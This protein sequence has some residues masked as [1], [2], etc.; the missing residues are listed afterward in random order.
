MAMDRLAWQAKV[1]LVVVSSSTVCEGRYPRV[2]PDVGF[3]TSRMLLKDS[4]LAA[5]EAMERQAARAVE[6]LASV[7]VDAI[8]YCCTVS[9]ALR[10]VAG[11]RDFCRDMKQRWKIPVTST[12]LAA[13]Q[14]LQHLGL[15]RVVVTSPY[16]ED[17]HEAER[18]Y[19]EQTGIEAIA[20][21]G[22]GFEKGNEFAK[23]TPEEIFQFSL[24]AWDDAADGLFISC[25]NFDAMPTVQA[26]EDRIGKPVVTSHSAT[27]WR[28]LALAG[29]ETP[30]SGHGRLLAERRGAR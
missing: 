10:G 9:G 23:V 14:A 13:T 29:V 27:L 30:I 17:H 16:P 2:A 18:I 25:M 3:F 5:I 11:D 24:N 28:V 4:G 26:L 8:A 22:M 1:G 7:P 6:E 15:K 12:M 19:L 21:H 20:M